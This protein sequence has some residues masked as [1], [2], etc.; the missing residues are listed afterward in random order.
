MFARL[1]M[2]REGRGMEDLGLHIEDEVGDP[3]RP[4]LG[5][6]GLGADA[7]ALGGVLVGPDMDDLVERADLGPPEAGQTR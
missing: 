6:H 7:I 2:R 3:G 4:D 1:E 5:R